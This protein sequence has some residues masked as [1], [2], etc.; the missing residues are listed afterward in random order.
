MFETVL[1]AIPNP[2]NGYG[3][4]TAITLAIV[5]ALDKAGVWKKLAPKI[6]IIFGR[7]GKNGKQATVRNNPGYKGGESPVCK[8][9]RDKII[10]LEK[11]MVNMKDEQKKDIEGVNKSIEKSCKENREDHKEIFRLL[12]KI[13]LTGG[14]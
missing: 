1:S 12:N 11:D 14:N 10:G 9:N 4:E 6:Q 13:K 5:Y 7:N 3:T 8:E 2:L